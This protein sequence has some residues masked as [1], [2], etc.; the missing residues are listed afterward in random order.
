MIQRPT[1]HPNNPASAATVGKNQRGAGEPQPPRRLDFHRH[2]LVLRLFG[3]LAVVQLGMAAMA[4]G[5]GMTAEPTI[6][7]DTLEAIRRLR[8]DAE[9]VEM[10]RCGLPE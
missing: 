4:L 7:P 8:T 3:C 6:P 1:G 5:N 10:T 9:L 2:L